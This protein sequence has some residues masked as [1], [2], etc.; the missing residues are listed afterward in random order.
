[1]AGSTRESSPSNLANNPKLSEYS[2]CCLQLRLENSAL[3]GGTDAGLFSDDLAAIARDEYGRHR[4]GSPA[5][6]VRLTAYVRMGQQRADWAPRYYRR[7]IQRALGQWRKTTR[8]EKVLILLL[9]S[10]LVYCLI[11]VCRLPGT[12]GISVES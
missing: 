5:G 7:D 1:M 2:Q 12:Q 6:V 10:G 3:E 11:L 4:L 8:V 9:D